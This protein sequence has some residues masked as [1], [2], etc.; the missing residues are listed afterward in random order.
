MQVKLKSGKM[1]DLSEEEIREM[2]HMY[3]DWFEN[4][5]DAEKLEDYFK[6]MHKKAHMNLEMISEETIETE[7]DMKD[8][9]VKVMK[10]G[11][12]A[13][14][15]DYIIEAIECKVSKMILESMEK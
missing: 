13:D 9:L 14:V 11:T 4:S 3:K 10:Y 2:L 12:R 1:L 7:K 15:A 6:E 5:F 8:A